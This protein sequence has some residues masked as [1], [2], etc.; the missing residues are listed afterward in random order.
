MQTYCYLQ[1]KLIAIF[2]ANLL[3]SSRQT[4][5]YLQG[6]LIAIFKQTYCYL[7][8]RLIAQ[9]PAVPNPSSAQAMHL[10]HLIASS[11]AK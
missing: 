1:C 5:C 7:Q 2:K 6:K 3:L 4:Y 11:K 10:M 9:G 8:G